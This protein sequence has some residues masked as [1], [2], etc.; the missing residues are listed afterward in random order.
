VNAQ[1][2]CPNERTG[3]EELGVDAGFDLPAIGRR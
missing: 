2:Q 1:F 3:K